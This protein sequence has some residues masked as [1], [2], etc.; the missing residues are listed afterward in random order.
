M[1]PTHASYNKDFEKVWKGDFSQLVKQFEYQMARMS[2]FVQPSL[3]TI[4]KS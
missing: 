4:A 2:A 1:D 3:P